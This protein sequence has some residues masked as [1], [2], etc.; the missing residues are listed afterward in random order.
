[1]PSLVMPL[2]ILLGIIIIFIWFCYSCVQY[3]ATQGLT[4]QETIAAVESRNAVQ[5]I[6]RQETKE[7][8]IERQKA[9]YEA[10]EMARREAE[11][12]RNNESKSSGVWKN[13]DKSKEAKRAQL[14]QELEV[15]KQKRNAKWAEIEAAEPTGDGRGVLRLARLGQEHIDIMDEIQELKRQIRNLD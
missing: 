3:A 15:L 8:Y 6:Q 4:V 7:Q 10:K 12:N 1:M 11:S 2:L 5:E 14:L 13:L 9:K